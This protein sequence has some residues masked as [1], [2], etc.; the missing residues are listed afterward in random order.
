MKKLLTPFTKQDFEGLYDFMLPIWKDTYVGVISSEQIDFLVN[1]YFKSENVATFLQKGYEYFKILNGGVLIF[2][3]RENDVFLDKLYLSENLRGK[4]VP[5][6]VFDF[7]LSR[8][9]DI[10]LNVN[11]GNKRAVKCYLKN[12]FEIE[13]SHDVVLENGM[14]NTDYVMRKKYKSE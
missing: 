8:K 2:L 7:L 1:K 6:L 3:E 4:N 9:K 12:G 10:T 5:S 13:L 14:I 11:R